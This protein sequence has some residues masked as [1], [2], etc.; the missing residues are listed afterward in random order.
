[1]RMRVCARTR[2]GSCAAGGA[3]R[4]CVCGGGGEGRGGWSATCL[5]E[6]IAGQRGERERR[7]T[8]LHVEQPQ[9]DAVHRAQRTVLGPPAALVVCRN[10][11]W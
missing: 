6:A 3:E 1:V 11:S 4:V 9:P 7:H 5:L 10:T 8:R 2:A